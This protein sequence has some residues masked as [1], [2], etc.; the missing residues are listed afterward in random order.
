MGTNNWEEV[1]H[2]LPEHLQQKLSDKSTREPSSLSFVCEGQK[3]CVALT[4]IPG[5][6][7]LMT[8]VFSVGY[9]DLSETYQGNPM[10]Q[11]GSRGHCIIS[12]FSNTTRVQD[13][14]LYK[15]SPSLKRIFANIPPSLTPWWKPRRLLTSLFFGNTVVWIPGLLPA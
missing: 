3:S 6:F 15:N 8:S 4:W 12:G 11:W 10:W 14:A 1:H 7:Q 2:F 5:L 13:M 9:V